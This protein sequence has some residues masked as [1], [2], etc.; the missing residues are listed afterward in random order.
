MKSLRVAVIG[1]G[2]MG[3]LHAKKLSQLPGIA[4]A[5]VADVDRKRA[6]TLA[7]LYGSRAY[8]DWQPA[9]AGVDAAVVAVPSEKHV[10]VL[11]ACLESGIHALV[12]K[13]MV[14]NVDD[15]AALTDLARARS[16]VLQ[17]AHIERFNAAFRAIASRIDRP[18]F[19]DAER[20]AEFKPRGA[21]VDVVLDLMIHDIDLAL[22]LAGA[23]VSDIRACGFSVLTPGIDI[24]NA[25][26]EFRSG[27][28]ADLSASRVSQAPVRKL[29][30]FQHNLYASADLQAGRLRYVRRGER[31]I[32]QSDESHEG[33]D[34]LALQDQAFV[35]AVRGEG[36]VAV[37]G[38]DGRRALEVALTV[39]RLVRERLDRFEAAT[40]TA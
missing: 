5:A 20:L 22:A 40:T 12:E 21:D 34:P 11:R 25:Y 27:C 36:P 28:V 8:V 30:V 14:T 23:E 1:A 29:R 37:T 6:E 9:L 15:A 24:A 10:E 18:L 4:V 32:E 35:A 13:P 39:G 31:A 33:A 19:I 3:S 2:H 26:I 38:D 17:V 7:A 16:L